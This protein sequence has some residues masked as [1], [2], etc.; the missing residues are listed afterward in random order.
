MYEKQIYSGSSA[1]LFF[2][3]QI[4]EEIGVKAPVN[5]KMFTGKGKLLEH[6]VN[7]EPVTMLQEKS[8]QN[9]SG[10]HILFVHT[11][12]PETIILIF[13][14]CD[15]ILWSTTRWWRSE[16]PQRFRA[17]RMGICQRCHG[18][19]GFDKPLPDEKRKY[20]LNPHLCCSCLTQKT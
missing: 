19:L 18:G 14:K 8:E 9:H 3:L 10:F 13:G 20:V 6:E 12:D 7:F 4:C 11:W 2:A 16:R 1:Q 15:V 5:V 17:A